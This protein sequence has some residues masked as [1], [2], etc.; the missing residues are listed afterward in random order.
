[1]SVSLYTGVDFGTSGIRLCVISPEGEIDAL[2]R[3][4]LP[5]ANSGTEPAIWLHMLLDSLS[6]L[7]LATRRALAAI[8]IDGT[9]GTVMACDTDLAPLAPALLYNDGRAIAEA[10]AIA[11]VSGENHIASTPTS[12]LAKV[13][14]LKSRLPASE[15]CLYLHQADWLTGQLSGRAGVSDYHNALKMGYDTEHLGWPEWI[16]TLSVADS[17]PGVVAPGA[18][19]S[20]VTRPRARQLMLS[21]DCLVRA[22]TTDSIAA[23][24]AAEVR[25][26]GHA[27]TSL[28]STLVLKL[29]STTRVEDAHS[30]VY[31]H[32]YGSIWLAGGASNTGGAVLR[33]YFGTEQLAGLSSRID[34]GQDS[35]LDYYPLIEPGERFP[36]CDPGLA[37]RMEPRPTD[38]A[39]F[40]HGLL[41]GM[42][43]IEAHGYAL[44]CEMGASP[45]ALVLTSG[46]GAIND[47]WRRIRER[48]LG[49]AV[50]PARHTEAAYGAALLAARG[51]AL[52]P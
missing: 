41:E 33:R 32:R 19:L 48:Q 42:A 45:V 31:S 1:M 7:P 16:K 37:P 20:T 22:G 26:P 51:T 40:L 5:L 34:A 8:A 21:P 23:F 27:V 46:G 2:E 50:R 36:T 44:L 47:T 52:L 3:L 25:T 9:S 12:S 10:E 17:L 29:L 13:L 18:A 24:M 14:W 15:P 43:R 38:D 30:G 39:G 49:V 4:D 35:G 28:G 6:R 11:Q